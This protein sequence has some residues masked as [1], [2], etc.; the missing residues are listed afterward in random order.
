MGRPAQPRHDGLG[1][2]QVKSEPL[3]EGSNHPAPI[4]LHGGLVFISNSAV[5]CPVAHV[6]SVRFQQVHG[7]DWSAGP[8]ARFRQRSAQPQAAASEGP[9]ERIG[10][11]LRVA[12]S[13]P[14]DVFLLAGHD[15]ACWL[16]L[17]TAGSHGSVE[18]FLEC[19]AAEFAI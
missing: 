1:R 14:R 16:V 9:G 13:R 3:L 12:S 11:A 17:V 6:I 2:R 7:M 19:L 10:V 5:A 18:E 8:A 4:V 15:R